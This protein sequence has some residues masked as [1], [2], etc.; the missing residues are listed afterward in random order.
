MKR[1]EECL[2]KQEKICEKQDCEAFFTLDNEMH[3]LIFAGCA[4]SRIW[5]IVREANV[6]YIRARVLD[7]SAVKLEMENLLRQ[8]QGIVQAIRNKDVQR[9]KKI[10]HW[11]VNKVLSDIEKIQKEYPEYF[12]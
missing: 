10:I 8:H 2:I 4:K 9:G 5:T 11:H 1:L 7:L 12:Q 6:D 3:S